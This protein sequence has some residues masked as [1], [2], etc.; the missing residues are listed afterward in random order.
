MNQRRE[1]WNSLLVHNAASKKTPSNQNLSSCLCLSISLSPYPS[2][3]LPLSQFVCVTVFL[4]FIM[5][6]F[7]SQKSHLTQI[8][9][10]IS[11]QIQNPSDPQAFCWRIYLAAT[12]LSGN[13]SRLTRTVGWLG[14]YEKYV[15]VHA[16]MLKT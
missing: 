4:F 6:V 9:L 12:S 8:A 15:T 1:N 13:L 11:F 2:V 10:Q 3:F 16:L 14:F 5:L 7:S